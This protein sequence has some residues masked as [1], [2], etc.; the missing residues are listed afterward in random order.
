MVPSVDI[1]LTLAEFHREV[2]RRPLQ[3]AC[4]YLAGTQAAL[5]LCVFATTGQLN[6][7]R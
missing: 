4:L 2:R 6:L 3:S 5:I 1:K 7:G